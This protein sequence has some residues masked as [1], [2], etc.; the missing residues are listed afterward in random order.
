MNGKKKFIRRLAGTMITIGFLGGWFIN[1]Y[2]YLLVLFVGLN[3]IQSSFTDFCPP[4]DF[5][6]RYLA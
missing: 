4:E 6:D 1:E 5:Y 2:I 3:M